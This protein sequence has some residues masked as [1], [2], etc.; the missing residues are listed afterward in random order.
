MKMKFLKN[1]VCA[2]LLVGAMVPAT[3]A[4]AEDGE[5]AW[6]LS[7]T[8][9]VT[10]DYRFRGVSQTTGE[11]AVQLG[12][13][14]AHESG[15]YGGVWFSNVDFDAFADI[16]TD[17]YLGYS[18][19]M[20]EETN[21][22]VALLYYLYNDEPSGGEYDYFELMA[23]LT[24]SYEGGAE[25]HGLVALTPE[26]FGETGFGWYIEGGVGFQIVEWLG[27]SANVGYQDVEDL[28]AYTTWNAGLTASWEIIDFDARYV[29]TDIGGFCDDVCDGAVVL[30]ATLNL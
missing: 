25:V 2:A 4:L 17:I 1:S 22:D 27:I 5:G 7:G 14:L 18:H 21:L 11:G 28:G 19:D 30:S 16:E 26:Y 20:S 3:V 15:F 24:H 29:D 6:D 13:E 8:L 12:V 10:N 23:T 9:T